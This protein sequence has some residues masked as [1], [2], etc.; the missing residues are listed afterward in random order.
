[1]AKAAFNGRYS[2]VE[3]PAAAPIPALEAFP[4]SVLSLEDGTVSWLHAEGTTVTVQ[5]ARTRAA[6][7]SLNV[8]A[9]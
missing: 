9:P 3:T 1:M 5:R 4:P 2:N 7:T 8:A 6:A